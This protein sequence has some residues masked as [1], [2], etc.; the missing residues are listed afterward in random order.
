MIRME[1]S[2]EHVDPCAMNLFID[3]EL[4]A[5]EEERIRQHVKHCRLCALYVDSGRELK[6]AIARAG[7]RFAPYAIDSANFNHTQNGNLV[8]FGS[9]P[10]LRAAVNQLQP[11]FR[12]VLLFCDV[13]ELSYIEIALILNISISKVMSRISDA[14]DALC[15]LLILQHGKSQ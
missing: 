5:G 12:E 7:F 2:T 9:T 8:F 14:R 13:E 11:T 6:A 10:T 15:Q 4:H 1:R 3:G